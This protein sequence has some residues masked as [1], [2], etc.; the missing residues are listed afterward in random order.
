MAGSVMGWLVQL[1]VEWLVQSL[2][3]RFSH[4]LASK[5]A[6]PGETCFS[7]W[8]Q[9]A[10]YRPAGWLELSPRPQVAGCCVSVV[11]FF[12]YLFMIFSLFFGF[13]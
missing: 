8:L 3:G 1:L 12:N 7:A 10:G 4:W 6:A 5:Q 13:T 9:L 11:K 2:A